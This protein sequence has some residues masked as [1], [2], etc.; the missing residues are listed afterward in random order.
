MHGPT[1]ART[2]PSGRRTREAVSV[3]GDWNYW[4]GDADPLHLRDDG[5]GIW[6]GFVAE[7]A[8]GQAYKYRIRS[9]HGGYVVDK[10]DPF[11]F[12]AEAPPATGSRIWTL[13]HEWSDGDWM[14]SRGAKNALDA[15]MSV[16]EVHPGSWRRK[17]GHFLDYRELAHQLAE[18]RDRDGLHACR[19]D[20]RHRASVLWLLGLPDHRLFRADLALRHAAGLH[21]FRRSPAPARHRRAAGLGALALPDRRARPRL[22]RRHPPLRACR[23]APGLPSGMEFQHL[24]L[25]PQRSPQLPDLVRRC[26]GSTSTTSMAC[27]S[28]LS[29]RCSTSTTRASTA[30]GFPTA[31]AAARTST[32]SSSCRR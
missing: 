5:T 11:A 6:Q 17:D 9:R 1:E 21:V 28:M 25:R 18:L 23:S 8:R 4:S 27:A 22:F 24:Q 31:M 12:Y 7:A 30:S 20:A 14:S 13:E 19:T 10:A 15:P 16:Y 26:S 32:P 2:L 3:V 29:P